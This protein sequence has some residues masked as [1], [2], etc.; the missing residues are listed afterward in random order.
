MKCKECGLLSGNYSLCSYCYNKQK[1][2]ELR[3]ERIRKHLCLDCGKSIDASYPNSRYCFVHVPK[4]LI[5]I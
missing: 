5:N 4:D 1:E 2:I 3:K